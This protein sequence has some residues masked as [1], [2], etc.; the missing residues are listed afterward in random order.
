M[1]SKRYNEILSE[2]RNSEVIFTFSFGLNLV[3][4]G[5]TCFW[6][7]I[8]NWISSNSRFVK[9]YFRFEQVKWRNRAIHCFLKEPRLFQV[10]FCAIV[11]FY[12]NP[13]RQ[14]RMGEICKINFVKSCNFSDFCNIL[15][16]RLLPKDY[17][18]TTLLY[19][20]AKLTP[21][22]FW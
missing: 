8:E 16:W 19:F 6:F 21:Y 14:K 9:S 18:N 2:I 20:V 15:Q 17:L 5:F 10:F 7:F 12:E 22:I 4:Q 13:D 3:A 1:R 11:L